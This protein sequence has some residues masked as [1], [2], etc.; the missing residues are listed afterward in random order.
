MD[1][2][3]NKRLLLNKY[4]LVLLPCEVTFENCRGV[5]TNSLTHLF[6]SEAFLLKNIIYIYVYIK[7]IYISYICNM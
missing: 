7:I 5:L 3:L 6:C 2:P 4:V 1:A